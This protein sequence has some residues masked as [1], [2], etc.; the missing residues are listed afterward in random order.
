MPQ[1]SSAAILSFNV[2][3]CFKYNCRFVRERLGLV[4]APFNDHS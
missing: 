4:E 1:P 2:S 3:F